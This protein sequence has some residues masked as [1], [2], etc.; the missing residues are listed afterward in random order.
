MAVV[1]VR[2]REYRSAGQQKGVGVSDPWVGSQDLAG[3]SPKPLGNTVES[4]KTPDGIYLSLTL[5]WRFR[6]LADR[7]ETWPVENISIL[8]LLHNFSYTTICRKFTE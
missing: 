8:L 5:L 3:L 1:G 7:R 4:I 2:Y 6:H